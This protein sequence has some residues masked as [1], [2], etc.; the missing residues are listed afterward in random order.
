MKAAGGLMVEKKAERIR[1]SE[2]GKSSLYIK[3]VILVL[4]HF[5]NNS[6]DNMW[7]SIICICGDETSCVCVGGWGFR[8]NRSRG[9]V[10]ASFG[11]M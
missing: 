2:L 1:T 7:N 3:L 8:K 6:V 11:L 4:I 5:W 10:N 9:E